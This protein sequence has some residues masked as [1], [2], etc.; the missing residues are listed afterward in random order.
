MRQRTLLPFRTVL[1]VYLGVLALSFVWDAAPRRVVPQFRVL[2][3]SMRRWCVSP[4]GQ[5]SGNDD[6]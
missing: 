1:L 2:V 4:D 5:T 3:A 6:G